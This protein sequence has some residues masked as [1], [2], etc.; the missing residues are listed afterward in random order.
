[1]FIREHV[2]R[3]R[4]HSAPL[5]TA[6][7]GV[8]AMG[9]QPAGQREFQGPPAAGRPSGGPKGRAGR[10]DSD[11]SLWQLPTALVPSYDVRFQLGC[12]GCGVFLDRWFVNDRWRGQDGDDESPEGGVGVVSADRAQTVAA[13]A[14][15]KLKKPPMYKVLLLNDDY[16]PMEFVVHVLQL[17]FAMDREKATRVMLAVHT[18]GSAVVGIFPRDIAEAKSEQINQYAQENEHPLLSRVEITD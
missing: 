2:N 18:Q 7:C 5:F 8:A 3:S 10:G 17:F 16:T 1:M 11:F 14:E 13:Q 12:G 15:P 9:T 4:S 6:G